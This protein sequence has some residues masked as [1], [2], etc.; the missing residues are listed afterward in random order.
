MTLERL[1]KIVTA[2]TLRVAGVPS[3]SIGILEDGKMSATVITNG[4]ENAETLYQACSIS[5][6]ITALAVGRLVDEGHFSY[7]APVGQQIPRDVLAG[8][9]EP[10]TA[11]LMDH[12]TVRMLLSHTSGLSQHGFPGYS[13]ET[14]NV[15]DILSGNP[16]S[17]TPKVRFD[18]F[19]GAQFSYSGGGFTVLQVFLEQVLQRPF[20]DIMYET[21]LKPL[22]MTRSTYGDLHPDEANYATAHLTASVQASVEYNKFAELA[23]AGLWTTPTDLLKAISAVQES[24]LSDSGFLKPTTAKEML[25]QVPQDSGMTT[26]ALGWGAD[27]S[28]FGHSGDNDPGYQCYVFGAHGGMVNGNLG[29]EGTRE[30]SKLPLRNG[31]AVM[32]NSVEG[33]KQIKKIVGA[34]FFLRQWPRFQSLV[35]QFGKADF[36]PYGVQGETG[37]EW[38][39]WAGRWEGGWSL[40]NEDGRPSLAFKAFPPQSLVSAAMPLDAN[41]HM[42]V[43][44]G[45][46]VAVRM[47]LKDGKPVMEVTQGGGSKILSPE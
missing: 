8:M 25:T 43:A 15:A 30:S 26:M 37:D 27:A 20:K 40:V 11:H 31:L 6:A 13:G 18:S 22:H 2:D 17:N 3:A 29:T 21:V 38:G 24:L 19:P 12:V 28:V 16:P 14:P 34:V 23:A 9:L 47:M 32:T 39:K 1:T 10:S 36:V 45:L 4:A 5:K 7:D 35:C 46:G 33:M 41:E 44:D 42:F